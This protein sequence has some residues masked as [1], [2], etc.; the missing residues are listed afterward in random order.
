MRDHGAASPEHR[1]PCHLRLRPSRLPVVMLVV[2]NGPPGVGKTTVSRL[3]AR[4]LEGTVCIQGDAL[5]AF[6]PPTPRAHLGRGSTYRAAAAL[7]CAYLRM[8]APR[9][10][11]DYCFLRP[12]HVAY[13][14]ENLDNTRVEFFTL[15]AS[16]PTV[17]AREQRRCGR[18][19][20]GAA[21]DECHAEI[22]RHLSD[23]GE[24]LDAREPPEVI[25]EALA[26]RLADRPMNADP[27]GGTQRPPA[28]TGC[29]D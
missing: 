10:I 11:F 2:V 5:R 28:R 19:P 7:A 1:A 8:G 6:S 22:Q 29:P 18:S 26:R 27:R 21:V 4:H 13:L 17:K 3:L 16:L 23:L 12:A 24:V 20:L 14:V 15:W 25:A 9:V